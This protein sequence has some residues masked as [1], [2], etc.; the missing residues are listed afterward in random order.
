MEKVTFKEFAL[1]ALASATHGFFVMGASIIE[2]FYRGIVFS[3]ALWI[4]I[5]IHSVF[6]QFSKFA[7]LFI[8]ITNGSV[9]ASAVDE[10]SSK[11]AELMMYTVIICGGMIVLCYIKNAYKALK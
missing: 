6:S 10:F 9:P 11:A 8:T 1:S 5:F 7:E 4:L 3:A 2:G